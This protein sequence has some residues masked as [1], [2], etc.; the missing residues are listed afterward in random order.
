M[1]NTKKM[2]KKKINGTKKILSWRLFLC[3]PYEFSCGDNNYRSLSVLVSMRPDRTRMLVSML[4]KWLLLFSFI[5][6]M[7]EQNI[8]SERKRLVQAKIKL[9][10]SRLWCALVCRR[11]QQQFATS[12]KCVVQNNEFLASTFGFRTHR[13]SFTL[14]KNNNERKNYRPLAA[15]TARVRTNCH[16][17]LLIIIN[18]EF[19]VK[20]RERDCFL[21]WKRCT[22]VYTHIRR[23]S[24]AKHPF[25]QPLR[26]MLFTQY[27]RD[28]FEE[29]IY[30]LWVDS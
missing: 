6:L 26:Q 11:N 13:T 24:F 28:Y 16:N 3:S 30:I 17:N 21:S 7:F 23:C 9:N 8:I 15:D 25:A 20:N 14:T 29:Y 5:L 27:M 22:I 12:A 2:P 4:C 18:T 1:P 19:C 10:L